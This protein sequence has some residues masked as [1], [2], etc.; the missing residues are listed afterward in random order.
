MEQ[1]RGQR[2]RHSGQIG[3]QHHADIAAYLLQLPMPQRDQVRS[4]LAI[5]F[6]YA[7]LLSFYMA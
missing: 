4:L 5:Y 7:L 1:Q 3:P 2:V 6:A